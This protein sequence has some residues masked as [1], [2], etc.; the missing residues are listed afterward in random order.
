MLSARGGKRDINFRLPTELIQSCRQTQ[1]TASE[2]IGRIP[3]FNLRTWTRQAIKRVSCKTTAAR[4]YLSKNPINRTS[5][6][7]SG[8]LSAS[9]QRDL[10]A[11]L[12]L[13][14]IR[15]DTT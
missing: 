13:I 11:R 6:A 1:P 4:F 5:A 7:M 14:S 8:L 12:M 9:A 15:Q 2:F 3:A 10:R